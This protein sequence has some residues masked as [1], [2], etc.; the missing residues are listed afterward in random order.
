MV[1]VKVEFVVIVYRFV[2][3]MVLL[4]ILSKLFFENGL[5]KGGWIGYWVKIVIYK[6]LIIECIFVF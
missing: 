5:G 4:W 1:I 2:Y 6:F 3:E